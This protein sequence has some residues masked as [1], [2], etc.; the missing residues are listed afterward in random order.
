[1]L[2]S[3][4]AVGPPPLGL[5]VV[6]RANRSIFSITLKDN[7]YQAQQIAG[8]G[9]V[10]TAELEEGTALQTT[11]SNPT[12]VCF[13]A[14]CLVFSDTGHRAIRL[15]TDAATHARRL[16][17]P[18]HAL[19]EAFGYYDEMDTAGCLLRLRIARDF[20]DEV[21]K[22]NAARTGQEYGQGPVGNV[23]L[24]V[25]KSLKCAV[26]ALEWLQE[27]ADML[28]IPYRV[29]A[30]IRAAAMTTLDVENF[31]PGMK[32][33]SP[34]PSA[35]EYARRRGDTI[36]ENTKRQTTTAYSYNT[37]HKSGHK[38]KHYTE[39]GAKSSST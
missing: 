8:S 28:N 1:M 29:R 25:R 3:S 22:Q 9:K 19:H 38:D 11:F 6:S 31:F 36:V 7:K 13:A 5:V 39:S 26:K 30:S 37:G 32:A 2:F 20:F 17:P 24:V 27:F 35:L 12:D 16:M 23:S 15:I 4:M 33:H 14:N 10:P 34:N 21:S 18:V